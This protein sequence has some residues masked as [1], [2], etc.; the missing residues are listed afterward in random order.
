MRNFIITFLVV[1]GVLLIGTFVLYQYCDSPVNRN[2]KKDVEFEIPEGMSTGGIARHL[3]DKDLIKSELFFIVRVKLNKPSLKASTYLLRKS[4]TTTQIIENLTKGSAYNPDAINITFHEGKRITD[5]AEVVAKKTKVSK[6]EFL[7][8]TKDQAY[9]GELIKKYWFLTDDIL[10]S[11]IYYPLEGY[12]A[13]NTYKFENKDVGA[14]EIIEKMLKQMEKDLKPIK[15]ELSESDEFSLHQYLTIA[16]ILELEGSDEASM[17]MISSIFRNRLAANMNLGSDV[18]TYYSLQLPM[19]GDL[20]GEQFNVVNAYNT[21]ALSMKGLPAGPICN[22]SM[23][24]IRAALEPT[25]NDYLYF[26]ADKKGKVYYTKSMDE[27]SKKVQ[28]LK[29]SGNWIW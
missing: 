20:S 16:S 9:L 4:M 29:D 21:R 28:E 10:N 19:N 17:K 15:S 25:D 24:A 2:S 1:C 7:N 12:L 23:K 18:T 6:E 5:Y 22:S 3:K 8:T 11:N 26:V 14:K 27:H 13:P